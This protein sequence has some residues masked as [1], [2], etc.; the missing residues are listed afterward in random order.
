MFCSTGIAVCSIAAS[1][2]HVLT[3][4]IVWSKTGTKEGVMAAAASSD[5]KHSNPLSL[6]DFLKSLELTSADPEPK[7]LPKWD[8]IYTDVSS[9]SGAVKEIPEP[10]PFIA[11]S[12]PAIV[13]ARSKQ[14][15]SGT[16]SGSGGPIVCQVLDIGSGNGRNV[17]PFLFGKHLPTT[18]AP[19]AIRFGVTA[20]DYSQAALTLLKTRIEQ[21]SKANAATAAT[22]SVSCYCIDLE[23]DRTTQTLIATPP[24]AAADAKSA[25]TNTTTT[26][27]TGS[28]GSTK[29]IAQVKP[30][31]LHAAFDVVT[32]TYYLDWTLLPVWCDA[33]KSG[34]FLL[35]ETFTPEHV[36]KYAPRFPV[37]FTLDTSEF[38]RVVEAF[39]F[40]IIKC[41]VTDDP[42]ASTHVASIIAQKL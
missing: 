31:P 12:I 38:K 21:H 2:N 8:G 26:T 6:H 13:D 29:S 9:R 23:S 5:A 20:I 11:Q 1:S 27:T 34:G 22:A 42:K 41:D 17:F 30:T 24:V 15:G 19:A 28:G 35:F 39:G 18:T 7:G 16:G 32:C 40:K 3:Q 10:L 4:D 14:S 33:V 25:T 37:R 36:T